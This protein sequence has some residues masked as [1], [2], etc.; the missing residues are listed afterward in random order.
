MNGGTVYVHRVNFTSLTS[1]K[2]SA[3]SVSAVFKAASTRM[4]IA[5]SFDVLLQHY[6]IAI[7]MF[8]GLLDSTGRLL[9]GFLNKIP[10]KQ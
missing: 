7:D 5:V 2:G 9:E 4:I 6:Y 3:L 8:Q 1:V 10:I